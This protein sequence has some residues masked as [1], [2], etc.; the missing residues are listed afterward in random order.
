MHPNTG[1]GG[2]A[3]CS[4]LTCRCVFWGHKWSVAPQIQLW[5]GSNPLKQIV[6]QTICD[7]TH[8]TVEYPTVL[9]VKHILSS[10]LIH[11]EIYQNTCAYMNNNDSKT[12][13]HFL[14]SSFPRVFVLILW[15]SVIRTDIFSLPF[16]KSESLQ[17]GVQ[18]F[19]WSCRI[20]CTVA[21]IANTVLVRK[22]QTAPL[23]TALKPH[24]GVC[25][26]QHMVLFILTA[27]CLQLSGSHKLCSAISWEVQLNVTLVQ[28]CF[29]WISGREDQQ[30]VVS[31][32]SHLLAVQNQRLDETSMTVSLITSLHISREP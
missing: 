1:M 29:D 6:C 21:S 4:P 16:T 25:F 17:T 3:P 7:L 13:P 9:C 5:V 11:C 10:S 23:I 2:G 28:I 31:W 27:I 24:K 32:R 26:V 19:Y 30:E 20:V 22:S 18:I 15:M 12:R 8:N 14:Q